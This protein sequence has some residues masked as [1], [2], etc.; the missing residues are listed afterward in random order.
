MPIDRNAVSI[1]DVRRV[2]SELNSVQ[3]ELRNLEK[4]NDDA[5]VK[6]QKIDAEIL[7]K[8][9]RLKII[10][11]RTEAEID[12][13]ELEHDSVKDRYESNIDTWKEK[14][15]RLDMDASRYDWLQSENEKLR[16]T[17]DSTLDDISSYRRYHAI[18]MHEKNKGMQTQRK[19]LEAKLRKDLNAMNI[20]YQND[21][22]NLMPD[23]QKKTMFDN[24]KLKDEMALQAIGMANLNMRHKKQLR[25]YEENL[26]KKKSL[27]QECNRLRL[28]IGELH[29][30][31]ILLMRTTSELETIKAELFEEINEI[32]NALGSCDTL[33]VIKMNQDDCMKSLQ[34]LKLDIEMWETRRGKF[35][36]LLFELKPT[37]NEEDIGLYSVDAFQYD[38]NFM[39]TLPSSQTKRKYRPMSRPGSPQSNTNSPSMTYSKYSNVHGHQKSDKQLR[40]GSSLL[41]RSNTSFSMFDKDKMMA[42]TTNTALTADD[43]RKYRKADK[44]LNKIFEIIEGKETAVVVRYDQPTEVNSLVKDDSSKALDENKS[45]FNPVINMLS[46]VSTE[47]MKV[48]TESKKHADD[49]KIYSDSLVIDTLWKDD[50]PYQYSSLDIVSRESDIS[51]QNEKIGLFDDNQQ[52]EIVEHFIDNEQNE[53][54]ENENSSGKNNY[55]TI[56]SQ[57]EHLSDNVPSFFISD[58]IKNEIHIDKQSL[59][60]NE[61]GS[62]WLRRI[63]RPRKLPYSTYHVNNSSN[64]ID[65]EDIGDNSMQKKT[66]VGPPIKPSKNK[67]LEEIKDFTL[68]IIDCEKTLKHSR[69]SI[70]YFKENIRK[71]KSSKE[72]QLSKSQNS[73]LTVFDDPLADATSKK[74]KASAIQSE[75]IIDG[76]FTY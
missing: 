34:N 18:R 12:Q 52:S 26:R 25:N 23:M 1:D 10:V 41:T 40:R 51:R 54:I 44:Y 76:K 72:M 15:R 9:S 66:M 53:K 6:I 64:N 55:D 27:E 5:A 70:N 69:G 61:E 42:V 67:F 28:G 22:F 57:D 60:S 45:D 20:N 47:I 3:Q 75:R 37:T 65:T 32:D 73:L 46:W 33:D 17:L 68:P 56:Q 30:K 62:S 50:S 19:A 31:K 63:Q 16:T 48:W 14:L 21:V 2:E 59:P 4:L 38:E 13:L 24:A 71:Q 36:D 8:D 7:D 74:F 11:E 49:S 43:I 58:A 29:T 39:E 35:D